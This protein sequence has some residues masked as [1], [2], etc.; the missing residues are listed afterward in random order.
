MSS[1]NNNQVNELFPGLDKIMQGY[2]G[3]LNSKASVYGHYQS[4]GPSPSPTQE[5]VL[6][7]TTSS[8]A[9][10][11]HH[12]QAA[13]NP[14]P[15]SAM[16]SGTVR[17]IPDTYSY[18]NN[19]LSPAANMKAPAATKQLFTAI[20]W[21][22]AA[23][24]QK[25]VT[26]KLSPA[27]NVQAPAA[28]KQTSTATT[29]APAATTQ[30]PVTTKLLPAVNVQAPAATKQMSTATAWA[31]AATTQKPVTTKL[32][33]AVNVQAPAATK[34]TSTATTR[35]PAATTQKPVTTKLLPAVNVQ[36][37]TTTKQM[38]TTAAQAPV[39][40]TQ[41]PATTKL[42]PA[43]NTQTLASIKQMPTAT[44]QAP[45]T[46]ASPTCKPSSNQAPMG[47]PATCLP[48]FAFPCQQTSP[49][50]LLL[51]IAR[52]GNQERQFPQSQTWEELLPNLV[53]YQ[54]EN[55]LTGY[56]TMEIMHQI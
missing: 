25:P 19:K 16:T 12:A 53:A 54:M 6:S 51:E 37:P 3:Y 50:P 24:T 20:A 26:T 23:T 46:L 5:S 18:V 27:V 52:L 11:A 7:P 39:A 38:S 49:H 32:L 33:P 30:K 41:K 55:V 40:S 28:T 15:L 2:A 13:A 21:A 44:A 48:A 8:M 14:N 4:S 22:P 36:A 29:R 1:F 34:Q 56:P 9:L 35:A 45:T 43:A 17:N 31:P 47:Q 42:L 10:F